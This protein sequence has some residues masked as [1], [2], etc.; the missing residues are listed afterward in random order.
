MDPRDP[1]SLAAAY[2][3][4]PQTPARVRKLLRLA[5]HGTRADFARTLAALPPAARGAVEAASV[6]LPFR[7]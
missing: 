5:R 2:L 4:G 1:Q 6:G 3:R 7:G